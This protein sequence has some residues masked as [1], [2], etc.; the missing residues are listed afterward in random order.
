M[1]SCPNTN[2]KE[3]K[4]LIK[5]GVKPFDAYKD[6]YE[7]GGKIRTVEQ[8]QEKLVNREKAAEEN[9][10]PEQTL[11]DLANRQ[12][13]QDQATYGINVS[14]LKNSKALEFANEV[15]KALGVSFQVV[16]GNEALEI[17]KNTNNPWSGEAA[18]FVGG[19]V[20]F[21]ADRMTTD[22]VLHEFAHPLVRA[23]AK[24]NESVFNNLYRQLE[25]SSEGQELITETKNSHSHLDPESKFFKEEVIV[26]AI[27]KA[28]QSALGEEVTE[29]KFAKFINE[30]LYQI[31]QMLR[32]VLGRD[33]AVSKLSLK[34]TIDDLANILAKSE[35]I[36]IDTELIA[37]EDIVAYNKDIREQL[38][39]DIANISEK[40]MVNAVRDLHDVMEGHLR[41]LRQNENY[42]DLAT[43]LFSENELGAIKGNLKEYRDAIINQADI[44]ED[45]LEESRT[46]T[47]AMASSLIHLRSSMQ[48]VLEHLQDLQELPD[49]QENTHKVYYYRHLLKHWE[50][51][52]NEFGSAVEDEQNKIAGNSP[53]AQLVN[54]IKVD[55]K[56][57]L[58]VIDKIYA[59]GAVETLY[60][61]LLPMNERITKRYQDII[62]ELEKKGADPKIIDRQ[63]RQLHGM[64]RAEL[65]EFNKLAE[66][67]KLGR[68]T[69]Q[70]I[71]RLK[72]LTLLSQSGV[73]VSK[74]KIE[75]L[76]KGQAQDA[77]WFNSNLEGYLYNTDPVI[78]GLAL[79]TKNAINEVMIVTQEKLNKFMEEIR[80][81]AEA[82]GYNASKLG[83]LGEQLGFVDTISR[84]DPE[85]GELKSRKVWTLLNPFKGYRSAKA[86]LET[87][88]REAEDNYLLSKSDEDKL[89]LETAEEELRQ[90]QKDYFYRE[91]TDAYYAKDDLLANDA[92]GLEAKRR[93][94]GV[95][96]RIK[97]LNEEMTGQ[98]DELDKQDELDM[99]WREYRQLYMMHDTKGNLKTGE[100]KE[101]SARLREHREF[102]RDLHEWKL[103]K[104]AFEKAYFDFQSEL[105]EAGLSEND[106]EWKTR[107]QQWKD[108]N[109]KIEVKQEFYDKRE[110][111]INEIKSIMNKIDAP[112]GK[113]EADVADI[114]EEILSMTN[115][116]KDSE[117]Q[118]D[119]TAMEPDAI[120]KI[121]DLQ[122]QL[123]EAKQDVIGRSGLTPRESQDLSDLYAK[124]K[125]KT[126]TPGERNYMNNLKA[127]KDNKG[128]DAYDIARL[129]SL[130]EALN[131]MQ[132]KDAT[133]YYVDL[134]NNYLDQLD[135]TNLKNTLGFN[136]VNKS[137]AEMILDKSTVDELMSQNAEFEKW[138]K[139]NHRLKTYYDKA[140]KTVVEKY[141]RL[142][143]WT[144]NRPSDKKYFEQYEIKDALGNTIETMN[145]TPSMKFYTR[146]VKTQYLQ[147]RILGETIDNQGQWLPKSVEDGAKDDRF[148]NEKY[149]AMK[150][151]T[152]PKVQAQFKL[153]EKVKQYHLENQ[154]GLA[155]RSKL[156]LDFP[157]YRKSNLEVVRTTNLIKA[158][159]GKVSAISLAAKRI[160]D[161]VKG[162]ADQAEGGLTKQDRHDLVR[163]DM[164]DNEMT[165]IPIAGLYDIDQEDV[166]TDILTNMMRYMASAERQ[167]KLVSISPIVR[168]IEN[169]VTNSTDTRV[170][171]DLDG[172]NFLARSLVRVKE[173]NK[174]VRVKAVRNFIEREFEGVT[175]KGALDKPI[176]NNFAN[177]LFK[178][179]SFSF[180]A[181]NIPSALKNSLGMKFQSMI[182]ASAGKYVGHVSLQKGNAWAYKTMGV[183]SFGGTLYNKKARGLDLQLVEIFDPIQGRFDEKFAEQLSRSAAQDVASF[184]WLYSPRKWVETQ[185]GI[186]LFGGMMY[187]QKIS[188]TLENGETVE[189]PYIEAFELVDGQITLKSGI[190]ARWSQNPEYLKIESTDSI[191]SL[192]KKYNTTEEVI[193]MSLKG[194]SLQSILTDISRIEELRKDELS[195]INF[196]E[197]KGNPA[198]QAKLT[199]RRDAINRKYDRQLEKTQVK[200]NNSE[201]KA[202]K[203]RIQQVQNNMGGAYAKFDQPDAQRYLAFRFISYL[204]RYFTTMATNRWGFSGSIK[205]PKPRANPGLGDVHMGFYVQTLQVLGDAIRT[206]GKKFSYM[207][208][209]E[210]AAALKMISEIGYLITLSML[211]G[212]IFGWDDDDPERYAKLRENQGG[213]IGFLGLVADDPQRGSF[214]PLGFLEVHALHML[215]QVRAENE[216]F[217]LLTGG[218]KQYSSLLDIKSVAFGP[219]TDSYFK[220]YD[221]TKKM[222]TG[223]P[224]ASYTRKVGPYEWQQKESYKLYNRIAKTF[225]LTGSSLDPSLA[226]QNFQSYQSKVR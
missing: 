56:K 72:E 153:L 24:E 164:F 15:S 30:A 117:G 57:S 172:K 63:Y 18:F 154:Q 158:G 35:K 192:A 68:M 96:D 162:E 194:K 213:A 150:N 29:G 183:L 129:D 94:D 215:M 119:G 140:T 88:V 3:W 159:K 109:T 65:Q 103:R 64:S 125:A 51:F 46:R 203:N 216:Q 28:G 165:D 25:E 182:E 173:R 106:L 31:K 202:M 90:F 77:N 23:I 124:A 27:T 33:L 131:I 209:E 130:Y 142:Y 167:K 221:D 148:R 108:A 207:T 190:D 54:T 157:R 86:E 53:L 4:A 113:T 22:L 214:N 181:L 184:S 89:T 81:L 200:I 7:T 105:R 224:K 156:Y 60:E 104:N 8:V 50:G 169:T 114:W 185:A 175:T 152:D 178:R 217:N 11:M 110:K 201:F 101:I 49:N 134:M 67:D 170:L 44:L 97:I 180:F 166:S 208:A 223:D 160:R 70:D 92:I 121:A 115:P 122:D 58:Q 204:R 171:D 39:E 76:L 116:Y 120:A 40:Q 107:M 210:K 218:M 37:E 82:A 136:A 128:L 137:T 100:E 19:K 206:G 211:C 75:Q 149:H 102:T 144:V 145:G 95:L 163:A 155:N 62:D 85:T 83:E 146:S 55:M 176:F 73:S 91:Y 123:I 135:T 151:S 78:G 87:A 21:L 188:R 71:R 61:Q 9:R 41:Q 38:S 225:G 189:I 6:F 112:E 161:F 191:S 219:T 177:L 45:N 126:I 220:I 36:N 179:A 42:S 66:K 2:S 69:A 84:R 133:D 99:L 205:N 34:T 118:T 197:G 47:Q 186:Q 222:I 26:K 14:Q 139:A 141:E 80:P 12:T 226:I 212:L 198:L 48:K 187:H 138:F 17:T 143:V 174:N 196:D 98:L 199:D 13:S 5:G 20:Y 10:I 43:I 193:E 59:K 127:R 79:Y 16:S 74:A 52:I 147:R 195:Q 93:R 111:I 132:S 1:N 168:A 32:R